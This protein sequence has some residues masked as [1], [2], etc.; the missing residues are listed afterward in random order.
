M[1]LNPA[2]S[3]LALIPHLPSRIDDVP[4]VEGLASIWVS[5]RERWLGKD[6]QLWGRAQHGKTW[7][8]EGSLGW[9]DAGVFMG[10]DRAGEASRHGCKQEGGHFGAATPYLQK[11]KTTL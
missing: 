6:G 9:R 3:R 2:A 7:V 10:W 8:G 4:R 1:S 11:K 5:N